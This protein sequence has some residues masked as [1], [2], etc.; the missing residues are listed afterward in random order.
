MRT[1]ARGHV[2]YGW[3][4]VAVSFLC[5]F[6][7]DAFGWYTFGIFIGPISRELGWT[8][9]ALTGALTLR[10]VVWGLMGPIIGPLVDTRHGARVLMSLGVLIAGAVSLAVSQVDELWQFYLLYG[11]IGALGM[12]GFG[13]LVTNALISKW[14][15]RKRGRAIG[16]ATM[17]ISISGLVFVPLSH[18]LIS[19]FGWRTTLLVLGFA[20][21]GLAFIP[22]VLLVR[23]RPEDMG[24]RPDGDTTEE[25]E[26]EVARAAGAS[27]VSRVEEI[28]SLREALR[29]KTLWLLLIGFNITGLALSGV[30]IHF[31]PYLE[32]KGIEPDVAATAVT[33]F[34]FCCALVKIPWGLLAERFPVRHCITACYVGCALSL[35]I[36]LNSQNVAF[37]FLYAIVYGVALGGDMVLKE[38]V[39]ADY[40]GRTFLG[41]I[42]GVTMPANLIAVA[43]GPLFAAWLRDVTGSYQLPYTIFFGTVLVGTCVIGLTRPPRKPGSRPAR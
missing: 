10:V 27:G 20:I 32:S 30:F 28:W 21:W 42:R 7:A 6:S 39:W 34:A 41:T 31:Y 43:G 9:V 37:V 40:F 24:L 35:L 19:D 3:F 23:R 38:L 11:V 22:V 13:G 36:L 16:I 17:G 12:V 29:T 18:V 1:K 2:F 25:V 26:V 8:T 14:F 33:T 15:V 5:W 4:V